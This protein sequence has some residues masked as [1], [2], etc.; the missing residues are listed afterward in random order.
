MAETGPKARKVVSQWSTPSSGPLALGESAETR[1]K[2]PKSRELVV[3]SI[4]WTTSSLGKVLKLG[5]KPEK[6]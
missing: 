1:P 5:Q 4:E 6:P 2:A 3:H